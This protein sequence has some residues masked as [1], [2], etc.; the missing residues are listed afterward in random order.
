MPR[1][2]GDE[3]RLWTLTYSQIAAWSGLKPSTVRSYC[4]RGDFDRASIESVLAWVNARRQARG[5]PMIGAP[6]E[7]PEE[8][9]A[10]EE[11]VANIVI[12]APPNPY[13]PL[14]GEYEL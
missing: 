11:P 14:T 3:D 13:N 9:I 10:E 8:D 4:Q 7:E 1:K 12:H 2:K 6:E 5:L